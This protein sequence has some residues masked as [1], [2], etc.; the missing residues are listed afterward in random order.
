MILSI[1][2]P[3]YRFPLSIISQAVWAYHRF[4]HS[5][6]DIQDELAFRG[7][8]VSHETIRKWCIKFANHFR[9]VIKKRERKPCDKWHLDEMSIMI[10]GEPFILWRAVDCDGYELDILLQKHR[11]KKTAIRFLS[12][13]LRSY[14]AP[15]L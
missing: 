13:L 10:N 6:K 15:R 5:Y 2:A 9:D 4:N 8:N 12:R 1:S 7:I 11:N 3:R 14:P